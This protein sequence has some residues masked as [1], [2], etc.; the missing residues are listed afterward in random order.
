[1]K[2]LLMLCLV[3]AS[4][5]CAS[6][7]LK[8]QGVVSLAASESALESAHDIERGLC[9]PAADKTQAITVCDGP[10]ATA[11]GLTSA[12]HQQMATMF[13]KAFEAERLAAT[14]LKTWKSGDPAPTSLAE[15]RRTVNELVSAVI[16]LLPQAKALVQKSQDAATEAT[17]TATAVGD[18]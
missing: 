8:Q 13:S 7:P 6:T 4:V 18:K 14:A 5:A 1:M 9:S 15:Y 10:S 3:L 17:K 2:R 16:S 12:I 11:V